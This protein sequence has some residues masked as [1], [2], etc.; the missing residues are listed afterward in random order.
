MNQQLAESYS[1]D[2]F[3]NG[4]LDFDPVAAFQDAAAVL[5]DDDVFTLPLTTNPIN[6]RE[7]MKSV[8]S[9]LAGGH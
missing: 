5:L 6:Y 7:A 3:D 2:E 1:E 4:S 9:P 8:Q